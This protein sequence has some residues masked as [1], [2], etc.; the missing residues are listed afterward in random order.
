MRIILLGPPGAGKGTQASRL[1]AKYGVPSIS[2]GDLFRARVKDPND[3]LGQQIKAILDAGT[4]VPDEITVK[5]I[6][7]RIDHD[8]CKNGFILDGFPRSVS[9]AEAL[10]KMLK[11][12][13]LKLDGVVQI[14]VDEEK[15][16]ER[17]AGRFSCSGCGEGY[18]D[19][20][21]QPAHANT[22]DKCHKTGTFVRRADDN[23]KTVRERMHIYHTQTEPI[24]PY[25]TE[26]GMLKTVDGMAD[27]D[28][29]T[30][31]IESA[32]EPKNGGAAANSP[33]KFG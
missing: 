24:L 26:R 9:Q 31:A 30:A 27:M 1:T 3:P 10:E 8:D 21:K 33:K 29:V 12:K 15:L 25:Y 16:V 14:G 6:S 11:E 32:L 5:M 13:N 4:L 17:I 18:H 28:H 2:T 20:F 22:C 23:E 19:K 7:E